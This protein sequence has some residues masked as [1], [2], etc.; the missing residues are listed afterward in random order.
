M[1]IVV[2]I[3]ASVD[4]SMASGKD[5]GS[6][7]VLL[8]LLKRILW[9][10]LLMIGFAMVLFQSSQDPQIDERPGPW[11]LYGILIALAIFMLHNT[12]DFSIA[13]PGPM[14]VFA[15][16]LGSALGVRTPS[17][18]GQKRQRK[19]AIASFCVALAA[20]IGV[21]IFFVLPI[22]DADARANSADDAIRT[23]DLRSADALLRS[24][25]AISPLSNS[26]YDYRAARVSMMS[27]APAAETDMLL[28]KAI[29]DN[30]MDANSY[31]TRAEHELHKPPAEQ[32]REQVLRDMYRAVTLDPNNVE[33]HLRLAHVY[34]LKGDAT[35]AQREIDIAREKN[36][37]LDP[38]NPKRLSDA[39]FQKRVAEINTM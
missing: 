3:C 20:W 25:I 22:A 7:F 24:A 38:E 17:V 35:S 21:A 11:L 29:A 1:A 37:L 18:A 30:P 15:L 9:F 39:D 23:G 2:N 28:S 31:M 6:A 16:L 33:G 13:E 32:N 5:G 27:N 8:D 26:D 19:V 4:F 34:Q 10:A 14:F 12:I 36:S